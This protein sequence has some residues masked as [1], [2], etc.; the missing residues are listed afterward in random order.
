[1]S[2][3]G[4]DINRGFKVLERALGG[5][6]FTWKGKD[7]PCIANEAES[8]K[9]FGAGGFALEADLV[10]FVRDDVLPDVGPAEKET[11]VYRGKTYRIDKIGNLP[12]DGQIK[13]MCNTP[14]A[15]F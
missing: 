2:R 3:I 14:T 4:A 6:V 1:M 12:G 13:L 8:S 7:Y 5:P 9:V 15:G 10:L 11:V